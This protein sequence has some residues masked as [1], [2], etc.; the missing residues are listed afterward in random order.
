M[1][2]R[3]SGT[4]GAAGTSAMPRSESAAVNFW[5]PRTEDDGK[6]V[7]QSNLRLRPPGQGIRSGRGPDG[8]RIVRVTPERDV[9][10]AHETFAPRGPRAL[11]SGS[12]WSGIRRQPAAG[13]TV[14]CSITPA[15]CGGCTGPV[16]RTYS[17]LQNRGGAIA[18]AAGI[19]PNRAG[20][21]QIRGR[22]GGR[23]ISFPT[24][25][26]TGDAAIRLPGQLESDLDNAIVCGHWLIEDRPHRI[27]DVDR[28]EDRSHVRSWA[29]AF[30]GEPG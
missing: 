12:R 30:S 5:Q 1:R 28:D 9:G 27:R 10:T 19:V 14:P 16:T 26:P 18:F 25:L 4:V 2:P 23:V 15:T 20:T 8:R 29:P 6:P 11:S 3:G 24:S 22:R 13:G 21:L 7:T 17:R